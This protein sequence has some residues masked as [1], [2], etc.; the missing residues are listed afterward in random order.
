MKKLSSVLLA[1]VFTMAIV[2]CGGGASTEAEAT[3]EE[4]VEET[5]DAVEAAPEEVEDAE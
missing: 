2:S 4:V 3:A 1:L 5:S